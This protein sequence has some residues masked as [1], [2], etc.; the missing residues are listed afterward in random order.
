MSWALIVIM[1]VSIL[2]VVGYLLWYRK[3]GPTPCPEWEK[4]LTLFIEGLTDPREEYNEH[5]DGCKRC[6]KCITYVLEEQLK[7]A[8]DLAKKVATARRR[9][10]EPVED[11]PWLG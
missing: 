6:Q 10:Q 7:E 11:R 8:Y 3:Q 4:D 1:A 2:S 5:L 9:N